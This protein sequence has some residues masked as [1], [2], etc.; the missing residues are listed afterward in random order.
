MGVHESPHDRPVSLHS[1]APAR[2]GKSTVRTAVWVLEPLDCNLG[3][4]ALC[5]H[6]YGRSVGVGGHDLA[7]TRTEQAVPLA[8]ATGTHHRRPPAHAELTAPEAELAIM[9]RR[10]RRSPRSSRRHRIHPEGTSP[11]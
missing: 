6:P 9:R 10:R 5:S 3:F 1:G 11:A 7:I 8:G 4:R 2:D